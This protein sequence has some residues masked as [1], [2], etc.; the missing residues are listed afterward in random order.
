[1]ASARFC[2]VAVDGVDG[3]GKTFL[4]DE[5]AD[6]LRRRG[7]SVVRVSADG[8]HNPREVRYRRGRAD[9]E[10]F[11]RD[12][13]DYEKLISLVLE[14]LSATG[15]GV[16]TPAVYDVATERPVAPSAVEAPAGA[17]LVVDGIFLH[18]DELV[19]FWDYSIWVDVAF[20]ISI[21]RGA[22]R[23]AGFGD[24]DPAHPSNRR[25]VEGQRLY[26]RECSPGER[27]TVVV[28]NAVLDAPVLRRPRR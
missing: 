15:S 9:P 3:A 14:P 17:V 2:R 16:Y 18:R 28:E 25:Y 5:L 24:P 22:A 26:I 20:E 6:A 1:M 10:G 11:F 21:P 27:A 7:R 23:G 8:F 13:Y 12:S 19:A 4:A